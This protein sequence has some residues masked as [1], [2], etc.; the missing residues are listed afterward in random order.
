MIKVSIEIDAFFL[1]HYPEQRLPSFVFYI[2]HRYNFKALKDDILSK[3]QA[4]NRNEF[5]GYLFSLG[6]AINQDLSEQPKTDAEIVFYFEQGMRHFCR[7]D[8]SIYFNNYIRFSNDPAYKAFHD[9]LARDMKKT[10]EK[11]IYKVYSDFLDNN[12]NLKDLT[13]YK[14][15]I[16]DLNFEHNFSDDLLKSF[17]KIHFSQYALTDGSDFWTYNKVTKGIKNEQNS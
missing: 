10:M 9:F 1:I 13:G 2:D 3:W 14:I 4:G 17:L 15:A 16:D 6:F 11:R 8:L 5:V 7:I 12:Q